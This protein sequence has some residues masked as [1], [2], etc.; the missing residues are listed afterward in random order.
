MRRLSILHGLLGLSLWACP[1]WAQTTGGPPNQIICNKIASFSGVSVATQ[2]VA[3][4]TGQVIF[5][6][7]WHVTNTAGSGTF[8]FSTGT[9]SACGTG[10]VNV[11]PAL[12]VTS[13]A[14]SADHI[15]YATVSSGVSGA[16]CVTPS[17]TTI[18]GLIFYSQF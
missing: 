18:S 12:N 15:D 17:V 1:V 11:T 3:A 4:A 7:G 10:T 5:V 2:M 14:P 13:S 6:C 16:F 9:G 8:Q